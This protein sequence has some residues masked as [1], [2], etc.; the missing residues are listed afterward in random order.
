MVINVQEMVEVL[1]MKLVYLFELSLNCR[2]TR[3]K[4]LDC[5]SAS[6]PP[7]NDKQYIKIRVTR[8][9]ISE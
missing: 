3:I 7:G 8:D 2:F 1:L 9:K 4:Q 5:S 6:R